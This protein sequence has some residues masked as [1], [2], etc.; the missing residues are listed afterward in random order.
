MKHKIQT[1]LQGLK[2]LDISELAL[3][4]LTAIVLPFDW[5]MALQA[6]LLLLLNTLVKMMVNGI[7]KHRQKSNSKPTLQHIPLSRWAR[8]ALWA[9]IAYYGLY[10]LS[11]LYTSNMATA[12]NYLTRKLPFVGFALFALVSNTSY[13]KYQHL[14]LIL[15]GFSAALVVKFFVR[16]FIMLFTTGTIKFSASFDP[17]HHTYMAMYILMAFIFLYGELFPHG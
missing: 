11:L 16:F 13:F 15:Y 9:L 12:Q 17:L 5:Q 1:L 14:R 3:L 2:P 4:L 6:M 8:W 10:L 7:A